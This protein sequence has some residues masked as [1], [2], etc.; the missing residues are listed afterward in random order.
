M[1]APSSMLMTNSG[2]K[3]I[4]INLTWK[5]HLEK[6]DSARRFSLW[7]HFYQF[8]LEKASRKGRFSQKILA[9]ETF[10]SV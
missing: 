2:N 1:S 7:R 3:G 6:A 8:D 4:Y 5:K 10:L 9:I